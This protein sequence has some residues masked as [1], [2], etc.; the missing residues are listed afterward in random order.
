MFVKHIV[1]INLGKI[2]TN[3]YTMNLRL[4]SAIVNSLQ[5]N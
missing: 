4:I 1:R 2:L 3:D 5:E